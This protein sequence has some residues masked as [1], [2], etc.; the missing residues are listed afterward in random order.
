MPFTVLHSENSPGSFHGLFGR[1]KTE[2]DSACDSFNAERDVVNRRSC[3]RWRDVRDFRAN[4]VAMILGKSS[5][6][7]KIFRIMYNRQIDFD[8]HD[9]EI[10]E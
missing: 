1:G 7:S 2:K 4:D 5:R 10:P 9:T 6:W 8:V 3:E